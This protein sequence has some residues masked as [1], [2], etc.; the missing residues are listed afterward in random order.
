MT[1][2]YALSRQSV[3]KIKQDLERL[4]TQV[5]NL[6]HGRLRAAYKAPQREDAI[7][8]KATATV[9]ARSGTDCTSGNFTIQNIS[10]A[11]TLSDSG[12]T[13]EVFNVGDA[14]V[15]SGD[16]LQLERDFRSG[17]WVTHAAAAGGGGGSSV[18]EISYVKAQGYWTYTGSA[19]PSTTS[20]VVA[21]VSVKKCDIDGTESGSAF[22]CYL[23]VTNTGNDPNVVPDQIFLAAETED[24]SDSSTSWS[25]I[26]GYEDAAIGTVRMMVD[27][28]PTGAASGWAKMDGVENADEG[29]GIDM[30][31][32]VPKHDCSVSAG[33]SNSGVADPSTTTGATA[34]GG[35]TGTG[36]TG[37]S[38]TLT[39]DA[40]TGTT[41]SAGSHTHT[42]TVSGTTGASS[43]TTGGSGVLTTSTHTIDLVW[44]EEDMSYTENVAG[45]QGI[46]DDDGDGDPEDYTHNHTIP[47]HS[48][49]IGSHTHS[50]SGS[51][52]TSSSGS[53]SHSIGSHQHE[54][55]S[56]THSV[57]SLSVSVA[58]HT[59]TIQKQLTRTMCFFERINNSDWS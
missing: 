17:R 51:A 31:G 50:F 14:A 54:I 55:S 18:R 40:S 1:D 25:G 34:P 4:R 9:A 10:A 6:E 58:S 44:C 8:G 48:H 59:H 20:E 41:G 46:T 49:S 38:G 2:A 27:N 7:I 23:P 45:F 56:H 30:T 29:S 57:P 35:S 21:S 28:N 43:G 33:T 22:D 3:D 5:A 12:R 32:A 36:T 26:S 19:Y 52:T 15:S 24:P 11:G 37:S 47:S 53:H 13:A 16:Y 39:T 42:V